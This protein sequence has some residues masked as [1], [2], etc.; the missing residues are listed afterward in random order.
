MV[1]DIVLNGLA[2]KNYYLFKK[3]TMNKTIIID[4]IEYELTPKYQYKVGDWIVYF[5]GNKNIIRKIISES[6]YRGSKSHVELDEAYGDWMTEEA[7]K[8]DKNKK[9]YYVKRLAIIEEVR[10][11]LLNLAIKKG[12]K[13]GSKIN[14]GKVSGA[15]INEIIQ[16]NSDYYPDYDQFA[17]SGIIIYS[18][19]EWATLQ[20]KPK[21]TF[22]GEKVEFEIVKNLEFGTYKTSI[23]IKCKGETG[24]HHQLAAI[25]THYFRPMSFGKI[26]VKSYT[27]KNNREYKNADKKFELPTWDANSDKSR[28]DDITIG[29]L[30]GKYSEL[31]DIFNYC[32][33]LLKTK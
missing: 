12:F 23:N 28:I 10:N 14:A 19:G 32:Q 6:Q 17:W 9:W 15:Y 11:H 4:D 13:V 2:I 27:L 8:E 25:L 20:E 21:F 18:K 24:S 16:S 22:G 31:V 29:C 7:V 26:S 33:E 5:D 1:L 30:T 3:Q